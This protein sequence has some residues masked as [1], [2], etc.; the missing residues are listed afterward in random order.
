MP[1]ISIIIPT[2]NRANLLERAVRSV[3][4]QTYRDFEILVIDDASKDNTQEMVKEK[5]TLEIDAG[6]LKFIRND[7]NIERSR[8]RNKGMEMAGGKYIALLDDDDFLAILLDYLNRKPAGGIVYSNYLILHENGF[9]EIGIKGINSGEGNYYRDLCI[10]RVLAHNSI[11]LFRKSVYDHLGGF[12]INLTYGEDREF[13]SRIAMNYDIG[14]IS[15]VTGCIYTH[16]GTYST[17]KTLEEH[18]YFNE[19]VWNIIEKNSNRYSYPLSNETKAEAYLF[20]S[21]YFQPNL[22]KTREYLLKAVSL[23]YKVL[24]RSNTWPLLFRILVGNRV[25]LS[26]KNIKAKWICC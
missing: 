18:A 19:N 10:R 23:D 3:L 12:N 25:Y 14:Y 5:F 9:S 13:F 7:K 21:N 1:E 26:L 15:S 22:Q 4:S 8:A 20:L 17:K 24:G 11:H 2:F 6:I 16:G